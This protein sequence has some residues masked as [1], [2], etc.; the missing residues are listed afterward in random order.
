[1]CDTVAEMLK[2]FRVAVMVLACFSEFLRMSLSGSNFDLGPKISTGGGNIPSSFAESSSL[3][4]SGGVSVIA[5]SG[6]R[7]FFVRCG[8]SLCFFGVG[9]LS[10]PASIM[11]NALSIISTALLP[12]CFWG[13]GAGFR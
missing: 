7:I 4:S 8:M 6:L 3:S 12:C 11:A 9:A 1:M 10:S 2:V 13:S 5:G